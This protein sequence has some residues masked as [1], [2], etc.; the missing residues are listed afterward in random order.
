MATLDT[1]AGLEL[2]DGPLVAAVSRDIPA[3]R[4]DI[5]RVLEIHQRWADWFPGVK[6]ATPTSLES[7]LGSTRVVNF[8]PFTAD[9]TFIAWDQPALF[10][11]RVN[12][13]R[14]CPPVLTAMVEAVELEE[15]GSA[16]TRV[17]YSQAFG[18]TPGR[19]G[20]VKALLKPMSLGISR[21]LAGLE[22]AT[23]NA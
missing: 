10:A 15:L 4:S 6:S 13:L 20:V 17:T 19:E 7:G 11:F 5:W 3:S 23:V 12:V 14:P 18:A 21:G 1:D 2:L 9:E 16:R 8:G 22:K